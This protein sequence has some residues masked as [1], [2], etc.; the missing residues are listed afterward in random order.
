VTLTATVAAATP[1][2][3][4]SPAPQGDVTFW[5][6]DD[7][8][9]TETLENVKGVMTA[10]GS[11]SDLPVGDDAITAV[12]SSDNSNFGSS[13]SEPFTETV[14]KADTQATV[15]A[16]SGR[17]VFGQQLTFTATVSAMAPSVMAPGVD[18]PT[19]TVTFNED[20]KLLGTATLSTLGGVTTATYSTNNLPP[21]NSPV[22]NSPIPIQV[23]YWGDGNFNG[24]TSK[25]IDVT[26][27]KADTRTA[28]AAS[29]CPS[30]YGSMVTFAATVS[31]VAPGSGDP[32]GNVAFYDGAYALGTV[33]LVAEGNASTAVCPPVS[34]LAA[35][36]HI[37]RAVYAGDNDFNSSSGWMEEQVAKAATRTTVSASPNPSLP[38]Q[39]VTF[40]ATVRATSPAPSTPT[41]TVTFKDGNKTLGIAVLSKGRATFT[42]SN[43]AVGS[44]DITASYSGGPLSNFNGSTSS[45][46]TEVVQNVDPA[47]AL[48]S[49]DAGDCPILAPL[50][51]ATAASS[52][53][54][55]AALLAVTD[56]SCTAWQ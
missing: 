32:T 54:N 34:T 47:A 11:T 27:L 56:E 13:E 21:N 10:T 30:V 50:A 46:V 24:C 37:I 18:T 12:Y 6:N 35:G 20:G 29:P 19:G 38:G 8:L 53:V 55:D 28:I 9:F 51:S 48:D 33:A 25:T 40:T 41:G 36:T 22:P 16:S 7:L 44:H 49:D 2:P 26:V 17:L 4:G 3:P 14:I 43:L 45:S 23:S 1:G 31:A 5:D 15:A 39:K 52:A 42:T